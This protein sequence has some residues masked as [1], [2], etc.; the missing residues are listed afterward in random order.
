MTFFFNSEHASVGCTVEV[1]K[2]CMLE[3][4]GDDDFDWEFQSVCFYM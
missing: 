3:Q 1:G 2:F 4:D